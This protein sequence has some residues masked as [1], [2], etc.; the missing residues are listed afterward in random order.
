MRFWLKMAQKWPFWT[1]FRAPMFIGQQFLMAQYWIFS[2]NYAFEVGNEICTKNNIK[3][4][5]IS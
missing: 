5:K 4:L 2:S 1:P 3:G